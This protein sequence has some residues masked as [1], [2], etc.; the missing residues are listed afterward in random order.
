MD[1]LDLVET[2]MA[3]E[4]EF[5]IEI[6]ESEAEKWKTVGDYVNYVSKA[7]GKPIFREGEKPAE[8]PPAGE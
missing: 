6:D 5:D 3:F 8:E 2:V 4:E 7:A 1:S